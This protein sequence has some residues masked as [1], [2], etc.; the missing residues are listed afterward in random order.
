MGARLQLTLKHYKPSANA[1]IMVPLPSVS[2]DAI[3]T[4]HY[5]TLGKFV[6]ESKFRSDPGAFIPHILKP[7]RDALAALITKPEVERVLLQRVRNK[8]CTYAQG[9]GNDGR[10]LLSGAQNGDSK[11]AADAYS[12]KI[13]VDGVVDLYEHYIIPLTKEVEV[14]IPFMSSNVFGK[15]K[16]SAY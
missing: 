5:L 12:A 13:D 3:H 10:P 15:L 8:T 7:N 4:T 9:F 6:S 2:N 16:L 14:R 1:S 11:A